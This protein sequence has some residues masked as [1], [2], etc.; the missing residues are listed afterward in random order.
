MTK[1]FRDPIDDLID[2]HVWLRRQAVVIDKGPDVLRGALEG[3][4]AVVNRASPALG[5][6]KTSTHEEKKRG[7]SA[8]RDDSR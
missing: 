5:A 8:P 3:G 6:P 2:A 1:K 4:D 7:L